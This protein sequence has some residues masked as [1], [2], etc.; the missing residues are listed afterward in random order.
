MLAFSFRSRVRVAAWH[1]QRSAP[2]RPAR[3]TIFQPV[4]SHKVQV[5]S[6]IVT[7]LFD[8]E[9]DVTRRN[10]GARNRFNRRDAPGTGS[11]HLILHFHGFHD[12]QAFAG[13]HLLAGLN[14]YTDHASGHG[15]GNGLRPAAVRRGAPPAQLAWIE[16]VDVKYTPINGDFARA[17]DGNRVAAPVD[18]NGPGSVVGGRCRIL[19]LDRRAS[20]ASIFEA[21]ARDRQVRR[22]TI[23]D[24]L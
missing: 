18:Q 23:N 12:D 5:A 8:H 21:F 22:F 2:E 19:A 14:Q 10:S 1:T 6:A 7:T 9:E 3:S 15:S 13:R 24:D 17:Q 11:L 16:N 20:F 4:P